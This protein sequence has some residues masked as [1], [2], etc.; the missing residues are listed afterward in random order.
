MRKNVLRLI[1]FA[2]RA[3]GKQLAIA[4]ILAILVTFIPEEKNSGLSVL[5]FIL[6]MVYFINMYTAMIRIYLTVPVMYNENT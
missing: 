4:I 5:I 1:L 2:L 3:G 6:D